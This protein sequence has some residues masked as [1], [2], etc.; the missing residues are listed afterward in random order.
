MK[1]LLLVST[2]LLSLNSQAGFLDANKNLRNIKTQVMKDFNKKQKMPCAN[3]SGNWQGKCSYSEEEVSIMKIEQYSCD[4]LFVDD[5]IYKTH[6][7]SKIEET[8]LYNE[9]LIKEV[10][11][12]KNRWNE[13]KTALIASSEFNTTA[14]Q[15]GPLKIQTTIE[16][17]DSNLIT[18]A[19]LGEE[20][21]SCVY[22]KTK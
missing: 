16:V 21:F 12:S 19:L 14:Y 9:T 1:A 18:T 22:E 11:L 20:N 7:D 2:L 17:K 5:V 15:D 3:F 10:M 8:Y 4:I 6:S 13:N